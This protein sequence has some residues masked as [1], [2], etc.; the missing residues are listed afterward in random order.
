M[1]GAPPLLIPPGWA[2][3]PL[4]PTETMLDASFGALSLYIAHARRFEP[5][6]L[7][8]AGRR[9][10]FHVPWRDKYAA[11]WRAMCGA[12]P[13]PPLDIINIQEVT[14]G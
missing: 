9:G 1:T 3:V 12:A 13:L 5:G 7:I 11:R 6:K 8:A 10:G 4:Q 2:L 14:H